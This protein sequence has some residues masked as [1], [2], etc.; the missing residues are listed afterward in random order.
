MLVE[1]AGDVNLFF[2]DHDD[3]HSAEIEIMIAGKYH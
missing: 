2:N 3:P 1:M